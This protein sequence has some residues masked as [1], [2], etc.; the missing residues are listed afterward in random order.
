MKLLSRLLLCGVLA[1]SSV[2]GIT[3]EENEEL[4]DDELLQYSDEQNISDRFIVY[5]DS[6]DFF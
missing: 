5:S 1:R 2:Y 3:I 4:H 6:D